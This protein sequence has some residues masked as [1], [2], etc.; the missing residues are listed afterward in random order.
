[1]SIFQLKETPGLEDER[2]EPNWEALEERQDRM[3]KL[4]EEMDAASKLTQAEFMAKEIARAEGPADFAVLEGVA[5]VLRVALARIGRHA[6]QDHLRTKLRDALDLADREKR[7]AYSKI[8]KA[9][10]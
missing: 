10:A 5:E 3:Q 8:E 4:R 1:M 2:H 6:G 9:R 7:A